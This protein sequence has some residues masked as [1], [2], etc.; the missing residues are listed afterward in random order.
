MR[1][2]QKPGTQEK[3][4]ISFHNISELSLGAVMRNRNCLELCES[5]PTVSGSV[6]TKI[7]RARSLLAHKSLQWRRQAR[8][9]KRCFIRKTFQ[10]LGAVSIASIERSEAVSYFAMCQGANLQRLPE[11]LCRDSLM[12]IIFSEYSRQYCT[13]KRWHASAGSH[14]NL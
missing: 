11:I 12:S 10:C 5:S 13:A 3:R 9:G 1:I 4:Q 7:G 8:L 2:P 14:P 6:C